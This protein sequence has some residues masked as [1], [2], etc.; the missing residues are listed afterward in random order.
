MTEEQAQAWLILEGWRPT[1][2]YRP[3][4]K[5]RWHGVV[6]QRGVLVALNGDQ[7]AD[8]IRTEEMPDIWW[9]RAIKREWL[10]TH[11]AAMFAAYIQEHNL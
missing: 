7:T 5:K 10:T 1:G 4:N 11:D 8:Q 3:G 6:N 2:K 9:T